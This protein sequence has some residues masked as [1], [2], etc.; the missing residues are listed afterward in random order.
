MT[1][2]KKPR[3]GVALAATAAIM[4]VATALGVGFALAASSTPG[5]SEPTADLSGD[6]TVGDV[7]PSRTSYARRGEGDQDTVQAR[8]TR[9]SP[10]EHDDDDDDD[11][12]D[13]DGDDDDDDDHAAR[14][15]TGAVAPTPRPAATTAGND[16]R[17]TTT[18]R[19]RRMRT[20]SS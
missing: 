6:A 18:Q 13:D 8:L 17:G 20:R 3:P 19:P 10:R 4:T 11:H 15:A 14:A 1:D 12:D 5:E 16:A 9:P 7:I 2:I